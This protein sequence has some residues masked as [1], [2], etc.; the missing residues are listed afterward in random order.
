MINRKNSISNITI[1][2]VVV[3]IILA[4]LSIPALAANEVTVSRSISK[5]NVGPSD[6]FTVTLRLTTNQELS[7]LSL[8]ET[9]PDGWELSERNSGRFT[10]SSN[11]QWVWSDT[12]SNITSGTSASIT[13]D[14]TVPDN[15]AA[16]TYSITGYASC[17][18]S[19]GASPS[20]TT[21]SGETQVVVEIED[22]APVLS[23]IG[24]KAVNEN[25]SLIFTIYATDANDD[26]I[27]YSAIGL[28]AGATFDGNT[29]VFSWSPAFTASGV[30]YVVFVATANGLT[31]SETVTITV[32]NIDRAPVLVP[33]GNKTTSMN[34]QLSFT[35]S[36][37]DLDGDSI[38]YSATGLPAGATF[39]TTSGTFSWTPFNGTEG[40]YVVTFTAESKG[41]VD[42][43]VVVISTSVDKSTL[44]AELLEA[45]LKVNTAIA[46]TEV[47]Q[48][49]Q[50][51]IDTFKGVIATVQAVADNSIATVAQVTQAATDLAT[52]EA[53]F[54]ASIIGI[55][56]TSPA[57]V[58][59]L[60]VE[61]V[62][63]NW[64][65]WTWVNPNDAD[66]SYVMIYM[67]NVFITN[68]ANSSVNFYNATGLSGGTSY[69]I[70][71]KT[72]DTSWNINATEVNSSAT[73]LQAPAISGLDG[74]SIT[75][76]SITLEWEA[77]NDTARVDI[78]RDGTLIVDV[79]GATSYT[80][81]NLTSGTTYSYTL[82]P[83]D[84]D[85]LAGGSASISLTTSSSK[86][87]GG[88]GGSSSK[89]S[90]GGGGGG[91][92]AE[93]FAN[94]AMKDVANAYMRMNMNVTYV[95]TR[96]G[97]AIQSIN[98]YSLK[99]SGQITSTIE[100]L[101][102]RSKLVN[103][104]PE[105]SIYKYVNIWVGKS[106]FAT[107]DN[108]KDA[109]IRFKVNSSWMQ[110]MGV[111]PSDIKLQRYSGNVWQILPTT[112][113]SNATGYVIFES[114]TPGFSPFAIT[115]IKK[116]SAPAAAYTE[117]K[118]Q[119][120]ASED[121]GNTPSQEDVASTEKPEPKRSSGWIFVIGLFAIVGIV[122]G[123]NW[124]LK[125]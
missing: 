64:I 51:S 12:A 6:T 17:T 95:F 119:S 28:P 16:G 124:L 41:L 39:G 125:R 37:T 96:D 69:T 103:S 25:S 92:S 117:E 53:A 118:M 22:V 74:T 30:Y 77:S 123:H 110:T 101:N 67:N 11:G 107:A 109:K 1:G 108:I 71:I 18:P 99:N 73:T 13:Y 2:L 93:G 40:I 81:G 14:V 121:V 46:G 8:K 88:G 62:G 68:T 59:G 89:S 24:S 27:T 116:V 104:T 4:L 47:G 114:Q 9:L 84:E 120:V 29:G 58:T 97:N 79:S 85:G 3:L 56:Q 94:V 60:T 33:I 66:L 34:T 98:L 122:L 31:D 54:D 65:K 19:D 21:V 23:N 86:S 26:A 10:Y 100:M 83:Y 38:V 90:G 70:G 35:I 43:E 91:G 48:Y 44:T 78:S 7:A 20:Q 111:S 42:S 15:A 61:G 76:N 87:G 113:V 36:A 55:D 112:H 52:A 72:V 102:N 75:K 80:D 82:V 106:G 5:D 49:P 32:G 50:S 105:G 57:P 63:P 45:N 115:A